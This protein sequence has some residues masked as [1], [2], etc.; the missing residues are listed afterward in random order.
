MGKYLGLCKPVMFS[1]FKSFE[2]RSP[3]S[4]ARSGGNFLDGKFPLCNVN[5][6]YIHV[7]LI[8]E[9]RVFFHF[10]SFFFPSE[11]PALIKGAVELSAI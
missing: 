8:G 7:L 4:F 5:G 10:Y 11:L 6:P 1:T 9:T 3:N 2:S